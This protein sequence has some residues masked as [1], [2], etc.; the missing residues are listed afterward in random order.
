[1]DIQY[2]VII[3][4]YNDPIRLERLLKSIPVKRTDIQ[5]IVV[6]DCSPNQKELLNLKN[7]YPQV[8]WYNTKKNSGA[9]AAR[10]IGLAHVKGDY[11][12][13]A[14]SDDQFTANAFDILDRTLTPGVDLTYYLAEAKI[15]NS[16][17]PSN[18][19][20]RFNNFCLKYIKNKNDKNLISLK[21]EHDV[22]WT[23]VN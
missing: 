10:N 16:S 9:G 20:A 7:K 17:A 13:F 2:S 15:E 18:R 3:P 5:I 22:T 11:L 4:H 19:A 6:D 8:E 12:L 14:D 1:M 23:K 21:S